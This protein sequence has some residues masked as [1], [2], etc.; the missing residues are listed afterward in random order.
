[1]DLENKKKQ[2]AYMIQIIGCILYVILIFVAIAFYPGGNPVDPNAPG[3]SFWQTSLSS[4]GASTLYWNEKFS[5]TYTIAHVIF[6]ITWYICVNIMLFGI[7]LGTAQ[8]IGRFTTVAALIILG[9]G[10]LKLEKA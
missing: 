7:D 6:T 1:M 10:A 5:R 8:K 2:L 3:Y 9:Y 4:L